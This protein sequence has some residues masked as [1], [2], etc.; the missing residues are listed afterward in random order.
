MLAKQ[1]PILLISLILMVTLASCSTQQNSSST[2]ISAATNTD[3]ATPLPTTPAQMMAITPTS[4]SGTDTAGTGVSMR[5]LW[6][7]NGYV[8]GPVSAVDEATAK[9]YLFKPLDI[10]ADKIVFNGQTCQNVTFTSETVTTDSYLADT[11]KT[12]Q[13]ALNIDFS[14]IQVFKTNCDLPGFKEYMRLGD[15]RLIVP[16]DGVFYFFEPRVNK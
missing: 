10:E 5:V 9:T 7:I 2:T 8:M 15:R 1:L 16:I 13:K 12:T 6:T 4:A 11:W 3:I 14:N